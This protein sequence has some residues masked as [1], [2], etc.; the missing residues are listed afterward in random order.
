MSD[1]NINSGGPEDKGG[2]GRLQK[3]N[4]YIMMFSPCFPFLSG[5]LS[6]L[7]FDDFMPYKSK[8]TMYGGWGVG[9]LLFIF[10]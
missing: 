8:G 1:T 5:V 7:L 6:V 3:T 9:R 10:E 2:L 4:Q